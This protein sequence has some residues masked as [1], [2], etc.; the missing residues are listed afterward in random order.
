MGWGRRSGHNMELALRES[1]TFVPWR[2]DLLLFLVIFA[3]I[4]PSSVLLSSTV[5]CIDH[6]IR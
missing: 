1:Y 3:S 4:L 5:T 6:P 2:C